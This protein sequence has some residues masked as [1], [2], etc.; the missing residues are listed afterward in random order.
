MAKNLFQMQKMNGLKNRTYI[1]SR[2]M[3]TLQS[4]VVKRCCR[5]T[6]RQI[7]A[8]MLQT[9]V[10]REESSKVRAVCH[11]YVCPFTNALIST[12]QFFFQLT[13]LHKSTQ[14][15]FC[16]ESIPLLAKKMRDKAVL[17]FWKRVSAFWKR[18]SAHFWKDFL[19]LCLKAAKFYLFPKILLIKMA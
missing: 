9:E 1:C 4:A 19:Y 7:P 12:C 8:E 13:A 3:G 16:A 14:A 17:A 15:F 5:W 11:T 10:S 6:R 2:Y 18:V